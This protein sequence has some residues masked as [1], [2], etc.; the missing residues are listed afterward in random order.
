ME[1]AVASTSSTEA[2][3]R[4]PPARL[5]AGRVVGAHGLRGR[6]RIRCDEGGAEGLLEA[7]HVFLGDRE[8]GARRCEVA[9]SASRAG[10]A[11]SASSSRRSPIA[12]QPKRCAAPASGSSPCSSRSF[13]RASTGPFQ[14]IGCEVEDGAGRRLGRVREIRSTGAQDL[15][16]VDG[17]GGAEHLIPAVQSWWREVDLAGR[18]IVVEL[19]PG[20]LE[21]ARH[22]S[23]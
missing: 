9:R 19:P 6:L 7:A 1:R 2:A 14:L 13:R 8:Q 22:R 16:V 17:A 4:P 15:L 11:R 10:A 21:P 5:L 18:R 3:R 20:L 12:R 23:G